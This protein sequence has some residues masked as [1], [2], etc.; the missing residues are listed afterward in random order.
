MAIIA[1]SDA[2]NEQESPLN[3]QSP[4]LESSPRRFKKKASSFTCILILFFSNSSPV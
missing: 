1:N 4:S 3:Q 2:N